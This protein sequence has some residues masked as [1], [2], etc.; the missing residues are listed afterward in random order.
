MHIGMTDVLYLL[1]RL[2]SFFVIISYVLFILS[3]FVVVCVCYS[4]FY[5]NNSE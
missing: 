3:P 2:S 1:C 5:R 4:L